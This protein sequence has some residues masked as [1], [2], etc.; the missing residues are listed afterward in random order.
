M[1][2]ILF[3][4]MLIKQIRQRLVDFFMLFLTNEQNKELWNYDVYN[5]VGTVCSELIWST[6]FKVNLLV[7]GGVK[8]RTRIT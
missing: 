2:E 7:V 3:M 5:L 8:Q 1:I 6:F 4:E